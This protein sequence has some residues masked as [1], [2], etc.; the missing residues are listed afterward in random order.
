[1]KKN[2][3]LFLLLSLILKMAGIVPV[4]S[5]ITLL[6]KEFVIVVP[7]F[8][9]KDWYY[10]NLDSIFGQHYSN[11][12]VI[13]I[14][15]CSDDGTGELVQEYIRVHGYQDR[16]TFIQN[17]ERY[18]PLYNRYVAIHSCPD[19]KIIV[20]I[21]GDDSLAHDEVLSYLNRIYSQEDIIMTVGNACKSSTGAKIGFRDYTQDEW[22]LFGIR[23]LGFRGVHPRTFYAGLFKKIKLEDLFQASH[24]YPMATD[25]A[26]LLPMF[27]MA[28][29][30]YK[31][32]TDILYIY[33]DQNPLNMARKGFQT[34]MYCDMMIRNKPSYERLEEFS[35]NNTPLQK[36]SMSCIA[37]MNQ[38]P[39]LHIAHDQIHTD[40]HF[41]NSCVITS[42]DYK[43][44]FFNTISKQVEFI[45]LACDLSTI[46]SFRINIRDRVA[47]F[48]K[49]IDSEYVLIAQDNF[50]HDNYFNY[51]HLQ[52][53]LENTQAS[54]IVLGHTPSEQVDK[55]YYVYNKSEDYKVYIARSWK[56]LDAFITHDGCMGLLIK[57]EILESM[58]DNMTVFYPNFN[59]FLACW[60]S[61]LPLQSILLMAFTH[62][63]K[64]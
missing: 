19:D 61:V 10:K 56:F 5:R 12:H 27:E 54:A 64:E 23:Q 60:Q 17:T 39:A 46:Y 29:G 52:E 34:Q 8:N 59:T 6:E 62:R 53:M 18:G 47:H 7:S 15:D 9:N 48:I 22:E 25:V 50:F 44:F 28:Q 63:I 3:L 30:R 45:D 4:S 38:K 42:Q 13:Y 16:C 21:D 55:E 1:M 33:N 51:A 11:F 37:F 35:F 43:P 24:L 36:K 26:C 41:D 31:Y 32:I 14:D 20:L 40:L 2:R 57:R 58:M 49:H